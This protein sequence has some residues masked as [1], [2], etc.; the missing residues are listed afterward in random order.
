MKPEFGDIR[1]NDENAIARIGFYYTTFDGQRDMHTDVFYV[2][3][4]NMSA[5]FGECARKKQFKDVYVTNV[6][7]VCGR[8]A[9]PSLTW[10]KGYWLK[11]LRKVTLDGMTEISKDMTDA[12]RLATSITRLRKWLNNRFAL[13]GYT[14]IEVLEK[15]A[16]YS[17]VSTDGSRAC[18]DVAMRQ[19][20]VDIFEGYCYCLISQV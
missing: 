20:L 2:T 11:L 14:V 5:S 3:M 6:V 17:N 9:K 16:D 4:S 8:Q 15:R 13:R 12:S 1:T 10:L 19:C 18:D 7:T